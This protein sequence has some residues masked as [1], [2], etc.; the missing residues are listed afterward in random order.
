[1][2]RKLL[3]NILKIVVSVGLLIFIFNII[4]LQQFLAVVNGANPT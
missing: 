4:D 1:M 2:N 3:L